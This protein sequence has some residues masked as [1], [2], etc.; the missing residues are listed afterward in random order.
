MSIEAIFLTQFI[1]SII[2]YTLLLLWIA[3]PWLDKQTTEIAIFWLALPHTFRHP[4][5]VFLVPQ[6][7]VSTL[8]SAFAIPAAYGDLFAGILA[9]LTMVAIKISWRIVIPLAWIFNIVGFVDLINALR[10][11]NVVEYFGTGWYIPTFIVPLLLVTHV[12]MFNR[13]IRASNTKL[14]TM[15]NK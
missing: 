5:L 7:Q 15:T 9:L 13:L 8:P 14:H 12:L 1:F 10:Q 3:V 11:T 4:G 2:V 6:L